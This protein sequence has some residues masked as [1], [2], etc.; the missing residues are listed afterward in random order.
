[1]SR[2]GFSLV[3]LMVALLLGSLISIAATQLFLV[4]RQTENL[5]QGV[6]YVQDQGRFALDYVGRDFMQAGHDP[7]G[8]VQPF[9][10]SGDADKISTDGTLMDTVVLEVHDGLDCVGNGSYTGLKKYSVVSNSLR[11]TY[12]SA[13][14]DPV[15]SAIIDGVA[16][17]KVLYGID[18][19]KWGTSGYGRAEVYTNSTGAA[20]LLDFS[21]AANKNNRIVSV[22]FGLLLSSEGVVTR[23]TPLT[24][25]TIK[26]LNTTF[27]SGTGA[28]QINF[29]DGRLYRVFSSTIEIRNQVESI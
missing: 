28:G 15:T 11:C 23:E 24:P 2:N 21:D 13:A 29:A 8:A 10:F 26:V 1:M 12:W 25:T 14:G 18:F 6:A 16:A 17:F 5:Q 19:D 27:N 22:R 20:S 3:E 7:L 9:Q 4:N